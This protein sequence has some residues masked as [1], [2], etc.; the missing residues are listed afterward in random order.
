MSML[1]LHRQFAAQHQCSQERDTKRIVSSFYVTRCR[2]GAAMSPAGRTRSASWTSPCYPPYRHA[3]IGTAS[4]RDLLAEA[5]VAH[6][7][8]RI[9]AEQCNP[10]LRGRVY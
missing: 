1:T 8:V 9:P 5:A 4:L 7:P 6:Q 10:A 3:G 2:W